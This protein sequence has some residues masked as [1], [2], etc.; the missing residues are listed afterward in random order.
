MK[1]EM[2]ASKEKIKHFLAKRPDIT[3]FSFCD[4]PPAND[5]VWGGTIQFDD[6][7]DWEKWPARYAIADSS[8]I[9]TFNIKLVAGHNFNDN[10]KNPELINQKWLGIL[11]MRTH[12]IS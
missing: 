9:K 4:N 6:R 11:D 3:S 7:S 10:P 1:K 2:F 12:M 5:K 8:Y